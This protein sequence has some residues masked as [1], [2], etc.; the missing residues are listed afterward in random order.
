MARKPIEDRWI[1]LG[2][3]TASLPE[4]LLLAQARGAV[5]FVTGAGISMASG[6]PN[7]RGL[8]L[9]VYERIDP[10][11]HQV[12]AA[13]LRS[14]TDRESM[15]RTNGLSAAQQAEVRRFSV[16][17]YDVVLGLLERRMDG[18]TLETSRVRQVVADLL[19]DPTKKAAPIH[20][21][22][23]RLSDRG[24]ARVIVTTNFDLLLEKAAPRGHAAKTHALGAIPRPSRNESFSGVLHIHGALSNNGIADLIL[25][26]HDFGEFYLRRRIVP[27]LIYDATRLFH[28]VLVGYSAND[29][30]M[31]Y[32]L[33]AVAADGFRF[34]DLKERF[35]FVGEASPPDPVVLEDW[36]GRGITPIPY[37][38]Q[39]DHAQLSDTLV[40]W[41]AL[42]P[43]PDKQS[44][45]DSEL[46]RIART[47]R[48]EAS[49]SDRDLFDH[50]FRR[51][52]KQ[53]RARIGS[54]LGRSRAA[55]DWLA[56]MTEIGNEPTEGGSQ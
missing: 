31:R 48:T 24:G 44:V 9:M 50:L 40:R 7:F 2:P 26:D 14:E 20:Q 33:N 16:G 49:E 55:T 51:G 30:P 4:R 25:T 56:A 39:S 53:E 34:D 52:S 27:D 19:S 23:M 35:V 5:L 10:P 22:L 6:F 32:L 45:V 8:V 15:A 29:A 41:A 28:I 37:S 11:V 54:V 3:G 43:G 36:R 46:R 18:R 13:V 21:A 12:L 1:S 17:E 42:A 38:T 47:S